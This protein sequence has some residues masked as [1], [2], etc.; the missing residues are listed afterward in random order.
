MAQAA[1]TN[2]KGETALD[3]KPGKA[4]K[5]G[6]PVRNLVLLG[7]LVAGL[8]IG[9]PVWRYYHNHETTDDAQVE[10]HIVSISPRMMGLVTSVR[11]IDNQSVRA[12][13]TLFTLDGTEMRIRVQLAEAD[14]QAAEAAAKGGVAGASAQAAQSQKTA[15]QA[16]MEAV[17]SNLKKA[18][19]D[20]QRVRELFQK[21]IASRAQ[22]DA[23]EAAFQSAQA[24]FAAA[25]EQTRGT[26]YGIAGA[27]AQVRAADA[28]LQAS[29]AALDAAKLQLSYAVVLA[30]ASGHIEK[31]S[32]EPGQQISLGQP[33]MAIV[34]AAPVWVVANLKETQLANVHAGQKVE[35]DVDAYPGKPVMGEVASIQFATGARFSLL[36]PDNASG[37][38]TKVV[39]RVPVRINISE[40]A[41]PDG[42]SLRPGMSV[43]VAIDVRQGG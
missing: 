3:G 42:P 39:Q 43:S 17:K 38:F 13:D 29:Q 34:D 5:S 32:L 6:K 30:P 18:Q 15:A 12:G 37:N 16:N 20:V 33:V 2:G 26:A 40:G 19:Q 35:I 21:D 1:E 11:V 36:P 41:G 31:V 4:G 10:G 14:L 28:R 9:F 8:A 22:L 23:A 24:G 25:S 27:N 7:L